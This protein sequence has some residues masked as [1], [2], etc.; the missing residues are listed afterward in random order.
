MHSVTFTIIAYSIYS[1]SNIGVKI[2]RR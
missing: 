1:V 2:W